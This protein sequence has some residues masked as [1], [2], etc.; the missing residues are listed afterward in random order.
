MSTPE[1]PGFPR[2]WRVEVSLDGASWKAVAEGR[3]TGPGT[4]ITFQPVSARVVRITLTT[5][6]EN[7]PPWSIQSLKLYGVP[8]S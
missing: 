7:G 1:G 6:V 4:T 2:G 5:S 8:G 3:S